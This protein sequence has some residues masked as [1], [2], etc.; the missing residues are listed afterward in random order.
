[1]KGKKGKDLRSMV[2]MLLKLGWA[3]LAHDGR[4][5]SVLFFNLGTLRCMIF[6]YENK[7]KKNTKNRA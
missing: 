5:F 1:M 2:S 6:G 7:S 3:E 4:C